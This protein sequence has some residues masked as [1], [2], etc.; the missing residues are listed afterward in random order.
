M[1]YN[2]VKRKLLDLYRHNVEPRIE[3]LH[4]EQIYQ[5]I[6]EQ[7]CRHHGIEDV[8]YPVGAAAGYSLM[9]LVTRILTELPVQRV[10][11]LG[12]GQSTVLIDR[13]LPTGGHHQSY[14]QSAIWAAAVSK[15]LKVAQVR[16]SPLVPT[17]CMGVDYEGFSDMQEHQFDLL[18]VDGPNGTDH[19]SR[20]D[21]VK[22]VAA[23]PAREFVVVIDDA[24]RPGERE[25]I[26][27]MT[28]LLSKRG[29]DYKL[30]YLSGRQLQAVITTPGFRAASFFF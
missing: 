10:V 20:H 18:L 27:S 8:F 24:Q 16:H 12:S 9:Y 25:T 15:R 5:R 28:R 7:Q 11:E 22:L 3:A 23:N 6:F 13:L 21:C 30:N 1:L 4:A 19:Y 29:I 2:F 17:T 26:E 14:E